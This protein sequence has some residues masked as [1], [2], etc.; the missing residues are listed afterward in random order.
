MTTHSHDRIL[1]S[2][3]D[4]GEAEEAAV[5]RSLRS[6]WVAPLGPDVDAFEAEIADYV[7]VSHALALNSG[8]AA[9]HLALLGAGA[10][11]GT[12]VLVPTLTFAA[13][14]NA[15]A[16]TGAEPYFVDCGPDGNV[17]VSLLCDTVESL[18]AAGETIAAVI[19]VDLLGRCA[20]YPAMEQFMRER[21]ITVIEDAAEGLGASLDGRACGS[22][23]D[24]AALSFNG[25]KIMTTAGGGML[26]GNDTEFMNR[27]R[28]L[29]TQARQPVAW[30]EHTDIGYN[31]RLA[32][33]SAALGRAQFSRLESM[34]ARRRTWREMYAEAL[35]P[36]LGRLLSTDDPRHTENCWLTALVLS[37]DSPHT[38]AKMI[39]RL[40]AAN[41][42][43][44]HLWKPMHRQPVFAEAR[45]ALTGMADDLFARS[46]TLPSGSSL[47]Q[48]DIERV[49][50]VLV[51]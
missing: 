13:T 31:Y 21:S 49:I 44:R 42:E 37:E 15:V 20:D 10:G 51:G 2:Q 9:L 29:S 4:V 23:G 36:Q 3:A 39:A 34:I 46:I 8:T 24:C 19:T 22:L 11:P 16:Y 12:V 50:E 17:D 25:N 40:G 26:L 5:I 43:A 38:P 48:D 47:Q 1:L 32:S 35:T 14:A 30:Y 41:I 45:A 27:A 18:R 7:G 28:Y 33:I 6:G